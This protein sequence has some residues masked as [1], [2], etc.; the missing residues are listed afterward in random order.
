MPKLIVK[1]LD[2]VPEALRE[3]YQEK[4]GKFVFQADDIRDHP[5]ALG[6]KSALDKEKEERRKAKKAAD[7]LKQQLEELGADPEEI[8]KILAEHAKSKDKKLLDEGKV[9][10]L[11]EQRTKKMRDEYEKKLQELTG[12]RDTTLGRLSEV[13]IDKSLMEAATRGKVRE[14]AIEDVL[15]RG[16]RI[17]KLKDG[18]PIP[19]NGEEVIYGKDS[20][21]IS[22][23]DW[24]GELQNTAPHL[25]EGSSGGGA[26]GSGGGGGGGG[27]KYVSRAEA[28][29]HL[30]A[31]ERG[32]VM[33]RD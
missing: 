29:K 8:K 2:E 7:E 30:A 24:I 28:S 25:F 3:F 11:I 21:P 22:M 5:D 17:W 27:V 20:K 26:G 16:K 4:D 10:E 1:S 18:Q 32:E 9:D 15:A 19:M 33:V 13:L 23:T 6:L 12:E 14:T 31:I